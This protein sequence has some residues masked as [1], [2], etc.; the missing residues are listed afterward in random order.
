MESEV[1]IDRTNRG[2]CLEMAQQ[3]TQRVSIWL[4]LETQQ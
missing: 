3:V 1:Y 2:D 4:N